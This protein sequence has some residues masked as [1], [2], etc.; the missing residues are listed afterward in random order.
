MNNNSDTT[1]QQF[2]V[3]AAQRLQNHLMELNTHYGAE[4][5]ETKAL[6]EQAFEEHR[7]IFDRELQE[8]L[9]TLGDTN[10]P[11]LLNELEQVKKEY[12]ERLRPSAI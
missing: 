11:W 2:T 4:N 3:W 1:V 6:L 12:L 10:N 5:V 9:A 7:E 8:E